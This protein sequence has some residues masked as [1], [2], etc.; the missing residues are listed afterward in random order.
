MASHTRIHNVQGVG[1]D[2]GN[3]INWLVY[4][5]A[6]KGGTIFMRSPSDQSKLYVSTN[7]AWYASFD[8]MVDFDSDTVRFER[9][10]GLDPGTETGK[11]LKV[12]NLV[13]GLEFETE[14]WTSTGTGAVDY[15]TA[16]GTALGV[17]GSGKLCEKQTSGAGSTQR[18]TLIGNHVIA[19]KRIQVRFVG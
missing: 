14:W 10:R 11:G 8:D 6:V 3:L 18:F 7:V 17:D 13:P 12:L 5:S 15:S 9:A 4:D 1:I 19:R 16:L 2:T